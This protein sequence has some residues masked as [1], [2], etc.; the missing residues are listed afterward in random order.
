MTDEN[1]MTALDTSVGADDKRSPNLCNTDRK[2]ENESDCKSFEEMQR[3]ILRM[4]DPSYLKTISM[5][6]NVS[7][8]RSSEAW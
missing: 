2:A 6:G 1:R 3:E 5:T 8:R 4:A 7:L